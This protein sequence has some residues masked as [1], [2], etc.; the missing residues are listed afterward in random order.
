M[1][2]NTTMCILVTL[3][4]VRILSL[5]NPNII[6]DGSTWDIVLTSLPRNQCRDLLISELRLGTD[7][8]GHEGD[9]FEDGVIL[10]FH[11]AEDLEHELTVEEGLFC[12]VG[13]LEVVDGG[14]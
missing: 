7:F 8:L 2:Y 14:D 4:E 9:L 12:L 6:F 13:F 3:N 5:I 11:G 1:L 10:L